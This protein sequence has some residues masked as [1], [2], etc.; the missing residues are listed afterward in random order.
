MVRGNN[1]YEKT[2]LHTDGLDDCSQRPWKIVL[3][4]MHQL[5]SDEGGM[6]GCIQDALENNPENDRIARAKVCASTIVRGCDL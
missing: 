1:S 4:Q 5:V 2:Y 6:Q 3:E